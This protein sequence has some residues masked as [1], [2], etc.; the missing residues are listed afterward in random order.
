M[1]QI[2]C[3]VQRKTGRKVVK[4]F[5]LNHKNYLNQ[6]LREVV[7]NVRTFFIK[8]EYPINLREVSKLDSFS[9]VKKLYQVT[10][11]V[12]RFINNLKR[13]VHSEVLNLSRCLDRTEISVSELLCLHDNQNNITQS[14][15]YSQLEKSLVLI[16]DEN[17]LF[18][19][20]GR[21]QSAPLP[22]DSR[23][24]ILLD[25]RHYLTELIVQDAHCKVL[26]NRVKQTL[27]HI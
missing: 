20:R 9:N 25:N 23:E 16:T 14:K 18:R 6:K 10:A 17:G 8:D 13:K 5:V 2:I 19:S 24:P 3:T 22:Y 15:N 4:N 1:V 12:L 7:K 11:W 26:H 27:T 21:L